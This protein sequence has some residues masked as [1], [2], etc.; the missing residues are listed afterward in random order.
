MEGGS[1][2]THDLY[3]FSSLRIFTGIEAP[4]WELLSV[5]G[6]SGRHGYVTV[7]LIPEYARL[8]LL[9]PSTLVTKSPQ[10]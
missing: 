5:G 4:K 3:P 2:G 1:R 8:I 10:P 9:K 6:L 7:V